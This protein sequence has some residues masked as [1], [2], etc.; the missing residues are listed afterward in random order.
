MSKISKHFDIREFVSKHTWDEWGMRSLWFLDPRLITL[1]EFTREWFGAPMMINNW[2]IGYSYQN[3]GYR[4]P[5]SSVGASEGQHRFGRALDFNIKGLSSDQVYDEILANEKDF[6]LAGI[7]TL[8]NKQYAKTWTHMDIRNTG[9][10]N[11]LIVNP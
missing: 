9:S 11:I 3:R 1:A 2:H 8:E 7:T 5:E 6:M 10:A 4:H